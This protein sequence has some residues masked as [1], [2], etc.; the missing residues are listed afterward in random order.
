M[1]HRI[2][3]GDDAEVMSGNPYHSAGAAARADFL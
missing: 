1:D 3:P 2:K